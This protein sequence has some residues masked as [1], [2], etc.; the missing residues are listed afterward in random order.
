MKT[1]G[2][3]L[4][5]VIAALL[6]LTHVARATDRRIETAAKTAL[7]K[8]EDDF[9]RMDLD[10][11]KKRLQAAE[12]V[13]GDS[14]CTAA[15]HAALLRDIGAM[16]LR[17]G[18]RDAALASFLRAKKLDPTIELNPSYDAPDLREAWASA[19]PVVRPSG[20]FK[21]VPAVEQSSRTPLPVYV[22]PTTNE[23]LTSVVV[24]YKNG[25]MKAF[26]RAV[27]KRLPSSSGWGG[28]IPCADVVDGTVSY[29]IQG[30]DKDSE[31]V[32]NVGDPEHTFTVPVHEHIA[33]PPPSL[34][35]EAPPKTCGDEDL[36]S[37]NLAD[38]ERCNEDRQ[39]KNGVCGASGRCRAPER[40]D[41]ALGSDL[42][43]PSEHARFWLGVA[44]S[45]DLTMLP[46][47]GNVCKLA[48]GVST[49]G[50][51]CTTPDGND[52]PANGAQNDAMTN[53]GTI[54]SSDIATGGVHVMVTLDY[55]PSANV[56]LGA[57][58]GFVLEAYPASA[59]SNAGKTI[60]APL[61]AELRGTYVLGDEPLAHA[62][63]A[64]YLFAAAGVARFDAGTTVMVHEANVAGDRA[65]EAWRVGGPFFAALGGGARYAFSVRTAFS[66]GLK[67][68]AAFGQGVFA[69]SVGP[70]LQLQYGF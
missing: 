68:T 47:Q 49:N 53:A 57:R 28:Y 13:C 30:F 27:L 10:K 6:F 2:H 19:S 62:G 69:P 54:P 1:R 3:F 56:L 64:P 8:A 26:R 5:A 67:A 66:A 61:H 50:Y 12:R 46:S 58:L 29:Y 60:G 38:G 34:P 63:L 24:K 42:A 23:A 48:G 31:L 18:A 51:W 36:E 39:C 70:E 55:A 15:T 40:D 59:A 20:D 65:V 14:A 22:E 43:G 11:A 7:K 37:L 21:H 32:A 16:E 9:L 41:A 4:A 35:G 17:L 45:L 52:Y 25:A 33:S 44:G